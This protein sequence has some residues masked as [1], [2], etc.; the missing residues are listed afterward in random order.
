ME[1]QTHRWSGRNMHFLTSRLSSGSTRVLSRGGVH[2]WLDRGFHVLHA[3]ELLR[4]WFNEIGLYGD[5]SQ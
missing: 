4:C 5:G 3:K 2:A 1:R